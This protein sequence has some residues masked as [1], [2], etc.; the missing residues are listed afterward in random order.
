[1]VCMEILN[2]ILTILYFIELLLRPLVNTD[3]ITKLLF[4]F[5]AYGNSNQLMFFSY[6]AGLLL[7]MLA[8]SRNDVKLI[9]KETP[10]KIRQPSSTQCEAL[11]NFLVMSIPAIMVFAG[12]R[13]TSALLPFIGQKFPLIWKVRLIVP[14]IIMFTVAITMLYYDRKE[15][16]DKQMTRRDAAMIGVSQLLGLIP[17]VYRLDISFITMRSLGF[18]RVASFRN[19]IL[20]SIPF[21]ICTC[22]ESAT[23]AWPRVI[24]LEH[25]DMLWAGVGGVMVFGAD[26]AFLNFTNWF[27]K[28]FTLLALALYRMVII[29][30]FF[31]YMYN[32]HQETIKPTSPTIIVEKTKTAEKIR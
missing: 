11:R 30:C 12:W 2:I 22:I 24:Y 7:A 26:L 14:H 21:Q 1:M 15:N 20:L 13:Y 25:I 5:I 32:M 10:L 18:S 31:L 28:K 23:M 3:C 19:F 16:T 6:E 9:C 17:G 27:L 4:D 8:Y 29:A